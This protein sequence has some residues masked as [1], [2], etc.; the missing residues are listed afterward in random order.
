MNKLILT[1]A[2]WIVY[3]CTSNAQPSALPLKVWSSEG[4][5]PLILYISG[6]GGFNNFSAGLCNN[7]HQA[8]FEVI[9]LNAKAYFSDQKTPEQTTLDLTPVLIKQFGHRKNQQLIMIGYSFG[10]DVMPFIVNRLP[11]V[12]SSKLLITLLMS[13]STTTDFE[14]HWQD[15]LGISRKRDRDIVAEINRMQSRRLVTFLGSDETD[16][17]VEAIKLKNYKNEW[18][19]GGHHYDGDIAALIERMMKYFR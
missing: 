12:I 18:L 17:P 10:A 3:T 7:L 9:A 11:D 5:M 14:T 4:S 6:D 19:T 1:F 8:G 16:F 13:P 2:A 15:M